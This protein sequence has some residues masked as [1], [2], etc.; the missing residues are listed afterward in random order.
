MDILVNNAGII[1]LHIHLND[2]FQKRTA[3]GRPFVGLSQLGGGEADLGGVDILVNN[4]GIIKRIPM[5]EMSV[6]DFR[7]VVERT[8]QGRPFVGLSQLGGGDDVHVVKGL[9]FPAHGVRPRSLRL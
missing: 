8:A 7:Q 1:L 9:I 2:S 3:Q 4:A 5:T 6:E